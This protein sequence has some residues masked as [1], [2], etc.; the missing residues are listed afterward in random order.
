M[1]ELQQAREL[2][3]RAS[4]FIEMH[5]EANLAPAVPTGRIQAIDLIF[6]REQVY[7]GVRQRIADREK[8]SG[9]P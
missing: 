8:I 5:P 3:Q 7:I 2:W 4:R 6:E 9:T 1:G